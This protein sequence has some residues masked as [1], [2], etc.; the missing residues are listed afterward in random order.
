MLS[1]RFSD[2][3]VAYDTSRFYIASSSLNRKIHSLSLQ[4]FTYDCLSSKC[5]NVAFSN[6]LHRLCAFKSNTNLNVPQSLGDSMN[7]DYSTSTGI[8]AQIKAEDVPISSTLRLYALFILHQPK[9]PLFTIIPPHALA[10][11]S[12]HHTTA[13]T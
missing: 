5:V 13:H 10:L 6:I 4:R 12:E 8:H 7:R 9:T 2:T 3:W 11:T 1:G